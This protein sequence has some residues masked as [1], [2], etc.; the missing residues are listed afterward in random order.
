MKNTRIIACNMNGR[1][2][3]ITSWG[4]DSDCEGDSPMNSQAPNR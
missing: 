2:C 1:S 3:V 4:S